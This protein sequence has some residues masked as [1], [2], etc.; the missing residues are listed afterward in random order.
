MSITNATAN[1]ALDKFLGQPIS[2]GGLWPS[3]VYIGLLLAEPNPDGSGVVE[4]SGGLA[5][6]RPGV[7]NSI[8]EWPGATSRQKTHASDIVFPQA[9]GG[10]WGTITHVGIFDA[11]SG[12]SLLAYGPLQTARP[13]NETD[14]FRFMAGFAPLTLTFPAS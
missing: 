2:G 7:T 11:A 4:P 9:I 12:G 14:I 10:N 8:A 13:V 1:A 3:T 6:S 5:Y